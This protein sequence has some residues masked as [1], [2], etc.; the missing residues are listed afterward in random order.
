MKKIF[1]FGCQRS[2]TTLLR[3]LLDSHSKI[4]CPPE[5]K[6]IYP[7]LKDV[8]ENSYVKNA[9]KT[10]NLNNVSIKPYIEKLIDN[11]LSDY[12]HKNKKKMW[13]DKSCHHIYIIDSINKIFSK[14]N[15][16]YV[17]LY[18]DGIEVANSFYIS[19]FHKF[20][21]IDY[22]S[23]KTILNSGLKHWLEY[24]ELLKNKLKKFDIFILK[25]NN[26]V[27]HTDFELTKLFKYIGLNYEKEIKLYMNFNHDNG[28]GDIKVLKHQRPTINNLKID[29]NY[30]DEKLL[31]KYKK[32]NNFF[33]KFS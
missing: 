6:F 10:L 33:N 1:I 9:F 31:L 19:K 17:C 30:F 21:F 11:I 28:F 5:T 32:L 23:K 14:K 7:L 13:A 25:Y 4:A 27:N 15:L 22:K 20:K 29:I 12:A 3:Y 24:N 26:L 18:R 16:R 8:F 2:G